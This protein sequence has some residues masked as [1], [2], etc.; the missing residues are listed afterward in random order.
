MESHSPSLRKKKPDLSKAASRK[1]FQAFL[2]SMALVPGSIFQFTNARKGL[3]PLGKLATQVWMDLESM[4]GLRCDAVQLRG[5]DMQGLLFLQSSSDAGRKLSLVFRLIKTRI[6]RAAEKAGL[7]G[8]A[9][10]RAHRMRVLETSREIAAARRALDREVQA[11]L[12][13]D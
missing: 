3:S 12:S 2:V 4:E 13:L 7:S 6:S 11:S 5:R 8:V 1:E 10:K 9:W